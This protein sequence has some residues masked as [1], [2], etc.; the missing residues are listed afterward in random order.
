MASLTQWAWV[1][2]ASGSWW[3][4]EK[5]GVLQSMGSQRVE[6]NWATELNGT[7]FLKPMLDHRF[8]RTW[9]SLNPLVDHVSRSSLYLCG[10]LSLFNCV[11]FFV[12]PWTVALPGSF[13]LEILQVKVLEW[14][15][16]LYSSGSSILGYQTHNSYVSS[17]GQAG[18]VSLLASGSACLYPPDSDVKT[19]L[20][21]RFV[22]RLWVLGYRLNF[23]TQ[24]LNTLV[25]K[26]FSFLFL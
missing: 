26:T 10:V 15:A 8:W 23:C 5:P 1:W 14:V 17:I 11:R 16:M 6:R 12:T 25:L 19:R 22:T 24:N 18:S 21:H 2:A 4:T 3:W 20:T 9:L 13:V 7:E